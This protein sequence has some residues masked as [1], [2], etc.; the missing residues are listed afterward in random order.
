M[1]LKLAGIGFSLMATAIAINA[2]DF[3]QNVRVVWSQKPQTEAMVVWDGDEI[4][5]GSVLL[6]DTVSRVSGHRD[7]AFRASVTGMGLYQEGPAKKPKDAE[8]DWAPSAPSTGFFYHHAP[9][10]NLT[11][12][13][14]YYLAVQT[15]D[16]IGREYHFKS[17]PKDGQTFKLIYGGDSRTH[18]DVAR[19]I[20][21]QISQ[22]VESDPS[23]AGLLHGGD[24][25][26]TTR[27][28]LW[29][30]WLEAYNLT[31]TED[32]KLLPIIPVIGNHDVPGNSPI[33]RQAYG[34]PGGLKDYY[35]CRIT[36]SIAIIC[37]NTEISAEGDQR[38]FLQKALTQLKTD[39]VKW[40]IA[41]FHK[42]VYPGV[43][44]PSAGRVSWVP[45]FE[46]YNIDLVLES[47]GHCIKRT[48]PIRGDIEADDGI[49][50]LGEGG[51]GAPQRNPKLD[52]WY[53]QGDNAF[54]GKGDHVMILEFAPD[55]IH[56]SAML[57]TG[58]IIDSASFKARR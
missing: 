48:V 18:V 20:N 30:Q 24:Y 36:P 44:K 29:K 27:R 26:V 21:E 10:K 53:L 6:Y 7:Y 3:A 2:A 50:Y 56:Y 23:I 17:A 54:A 51:Y 25:A 12:D 58:E 32:G 33:F 14:V 34:Y 5:D 8:D 9:I 13:T 1:K 49:V 31:T 45:L 4:L 11:P 37:L 39:Q 35:S 40:Q 57:N 38:I 15:A 28:D 52:R 47:D 41:A 43:K 55:I 46:E 19:Q 16:G 22:M 42:P